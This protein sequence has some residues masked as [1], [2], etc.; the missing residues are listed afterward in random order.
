LSKRKNPVSVFHYRDRG[1]LPAT[2]LN[3]LGT[4]GFS[5][6]DERERFSLQEMI[7]HFELN[8][9]RAG[10]PVFDVRKLDAFNGDDI[11]ALDSEVLGKMLI[12]HA[13]GGGRLPK[14]VELTRE[15]IA[16]LD[17]FIPYAAFFFG[18][19][20]DYGAVLPH[21]RL[22]K[23]SRAEIM[24]ILRKFVDELEK[25]PSARAFT[26]ETLEPFARSFCERH[27]W[28]PRE[29]FTLLRI[30]ATGRTAAPPLFDTLVALGKDRV[31]M[32]LR[33]AVSRLQA[34]PDW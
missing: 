21:F 16:H 19:A 25:D 30:S 20:V 26:A 4:L 8:R 33:D 15:R 7:E 2:F 28:K 9:L 13:F 31:R 12:D 32:R 27:G 34:E 10:G 18:G 5:M 17:D 29:V 23:R 14:L 6:P 1:Y 22:K 3:F 24:E 11:R